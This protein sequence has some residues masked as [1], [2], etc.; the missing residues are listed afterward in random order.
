M[1]RLAIPGLLLIASCDG[2][3]VLSN[4]EEGALNAGIKLATGVAL[5]APLPTDATSSLQISRWEQTT[6]ENGRRSEHVMWTTVMPA[7]RFEPSELSSVMAL[8]LTSDGTFLTLSLTPT[9]SGVGTLFVDGDL[10]DD[11]WKLTFE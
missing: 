10:Y 1:L 2:T 5:L 8:E 7:V 4:G 9:S 3:R 11:S 6:D